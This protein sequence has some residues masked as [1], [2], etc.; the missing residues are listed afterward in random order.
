MVFDVFWC[1]TC[2]SILSLHRSV[3]VHFSTLW[4][5]PSFFKSLLHSWKSI[6]FE[7]RTHQQQA[8]L[9]TLWRIAKQQ[10]FKR[11][12]DMWAKTTRTY[13]AT[14]D[15]FYTREK[16]RRE[17]Y[18]KVWII[19]KIASLP[20]LHN[21]SILWV[22]GMLCNHNTTKVHF[23]IRGPK[24]YLGWHN[25][26]ACSVWKFH[27]SSFLFITIVLLSPYQYCNID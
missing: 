17:T 18:I 8:P 22:V 6:D 14:I 3:N 5:R 1:P 21:F 12:K 11:G 13:A 23:L 4:P 2:K 15:M 9:G 7:K 20:F 16:R 26:P 19:E 10:S 27:I 25:S 24:F